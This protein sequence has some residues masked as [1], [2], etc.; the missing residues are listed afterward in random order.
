M[1]SAIITL[2]IDPKTKVEAK[3]FASSFGLSLSSLVNGLLLNVVNTGE[4]KF[5]QKPEVLNDHTVADLEE[6]ERDYKAGKFCS[7][8]NVD[9]FIAHLNRT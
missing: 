5:T 6:S 4:V 8:S 9:D 7:F 1:K 2:K 3:K